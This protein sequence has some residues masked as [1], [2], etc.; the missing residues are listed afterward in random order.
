MTH[1]WPDEVTHPS[2]GSYYCYHG[3]SVKGYTRTWPRAGASI[4]AVYTIC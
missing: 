1:D 3:Y 4:N 2:A